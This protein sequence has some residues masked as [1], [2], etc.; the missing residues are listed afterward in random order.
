[1]FKKKQEKVL[2]TSVVIILWEVLRRLRT[3]A[4]E[5]REP[6]DPPPQEPTAEETIAEV[7]EAQPVQAREG[8]GQR[9]GR[10]R[11]GGERRKPDIPRFSFKRLAREV[12]QEINK[13][14]YI[15]KEAIYA[16][17][18]AVENYMRELFNDASIA[19]LCSKRALVKSRDLQLVRSVKG[20]K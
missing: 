11:P 4:A 13:K 17:H 3:K 15:E 16:L 6:Y 10:Y 5:L 14:V 12:L 8:R 18:T 2:Q 7:P 1:M 19:A 9:G 20:P